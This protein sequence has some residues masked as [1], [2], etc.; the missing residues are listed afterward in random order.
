MSCITSYSYWHSSALNQV[1]TSHDG[2]RA[3]E[4]SA[5]MVELVARELADLISAMSR[6]YMGQGGVTEEQLRGQINK[7]TLPFN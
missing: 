5:K 3:G 1:T 2:L 6:Q 7:G 4:Q